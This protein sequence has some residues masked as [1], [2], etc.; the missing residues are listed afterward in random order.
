LYMFCFVSQRV[1]DF[2]SET[3]QQC[4][5]RLR[6]VLPGRY[7]APYFQYYFSRLH[8]PYKYLVNPLSWLTYHYQCDDWSRRRYENYY[9]FRMYLAGPCLLATYGQENDS[10][11][12]HLASSILEIQGDWYT[13]RESYMKL[14]FRYA[15]RFN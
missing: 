9:M 3:V 14:F 1:F 4:V 13:L 12:F 8:I 7:Y 10:E 5:E 15:D 11:L 6:E 2:R